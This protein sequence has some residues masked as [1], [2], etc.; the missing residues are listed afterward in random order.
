MKDVSSSLSTNAVCSKSISYGLVSWPWLIA[1]MLIITSCSKIPSWYRIQQIVNSEP[2]LAKDVFGERPI[3]TNQWT[4]KATLPTHIG[5]R[6]YTGSN[7][8]SLAAMDALT[9]DPG[10]RRFTDGMACYAEE[11]G[12]FWL[13]HGGGMPMDIDLFVRSRCAISTA[14]IQTLY[15]YLDLDAG[16]SSSAFLAD[17]SVVNDMLSSASEGTIIGAWG[18]QN[19]SSAVIVVV[20]G[21]PQIAVKATPMSTEGI[22]TVSIEISSPRRGSSVQAFSTIGKFGYVTCEASRTPDKNLAFQCPLDDERDYTLVEL[23]ATEPERV[24]GFVTFSAMFA[25]DS[26]LLPSIYNSRTPEN[27]GKQQAHSLATYIRILNSIRKIEALRPISADPKHSETV[28][29]LVPHLLAAQHTGD[30]DFADEVALGMT[31]GWGVPGIIQG[32]R[33]NSVQGHYQW[34]PERVLHASIESPAYRSVALNPDVRTVALGIHSD[35]EYT[36]RASAIVGFSFFENRAYHEEEDEL[37]EVLDRRRKEKGRGPVTRLDSGKIADFLQEAASRIRGNETT[38]D[39]QIY[40]IPGKMKDVTGVDH[41]VW[42]IETS[43][44]E[45]LRYDFPISLMSAPNASVGLFISHYWSNRL[46]W[47]AYL[48]FIAYS[49]DG[50]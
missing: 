21:R 36:A 47:G 45:P 29:K 6:E 5:V 32:A 49:T 4:M 8:T 19:S 3:Q 13:Q 25:V 26:S 7:R 31:A 43:H 17:Q 9:R 10:A 23:V 42:S 37:F 15:R 35:Q 44:L 24:L 14:R 11:L 27:N 41:R 30:E 48:V 39:I 1:A 12:R 46:P 28:T 50:E 34:S 16:E 20:I 40:E 38:P 22:P 18:G 33:F 2:P